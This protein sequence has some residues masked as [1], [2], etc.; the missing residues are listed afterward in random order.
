M[1]G[2]LAFYSDD[3]SLNPAEVYSICKML[4]EK[5]AEVGSFQ[6]FDLS[7]WMLHVM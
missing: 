3:P 1:V 5:E 2:V 4:L 7:H 6:S